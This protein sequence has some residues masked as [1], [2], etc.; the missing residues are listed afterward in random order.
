MVKMFHFQA[1]TT[2]II[3]GGTGTGKSH[4]MKEIILNKSIKPK[5][6]TIYWICQVRNPKFE[7]D[8]KDQVT[9]MEGIPESIKELVNTPEHTLLILDDC[10]SVLGNR[11]D[12]LELY[13]VG[14]HHWNTTVF[15]LVQNLYFYGRHGVSI[16]RNKHYA[17]LLNS[18][19]DANEVMTMS[20]Q[21]FPEKPRF[22]RPS[23]R[24]CLT[25]YRRNRARAVPGGNC[26]R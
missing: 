17:I 5:P 11:D 10:M 13:T 15:S 22:P 23:T 26:T 14:S 1:P 18:P 12:I 16:R 21:M 8:L 25:S 24:G 4:L 9:F 19:T 6:A 2:A 3:S 7:H 20:R